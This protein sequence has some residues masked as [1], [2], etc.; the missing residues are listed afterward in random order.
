MITTNTTLSRERPASLIVIRIGFHGT[1]LVT[2]YLP[3]V[4]VECRQVRQGTA[5]ILPFTLVN[6]R[7][8]LRACC[9]D[10]F[11]YGTET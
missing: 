3:V 6:R 8:F 4:S 7:K 1:Y 2:A 9:Y 10:G 11:Q 5:M